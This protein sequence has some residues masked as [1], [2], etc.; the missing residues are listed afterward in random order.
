MARD[1]SGVCKLCGK[2]AQLTKEH[3]PSKGAYDRLSYRV[4]VLSGDQVFEGG[5]GEH[6]QRGFHARVLCAKCNNQTGAWYGDEFSA[7][8]KWGFQLLHAMR[9]ERPPLVA[10]Y[11]GYPARIAKQVISTMIA[12]AEDGFAERRPHLRDFVLDRHRVLE[13]DQLRLTMYL[14]PTRTGRSTGVVRALKR[15]S[16]AHVLIEFALRPFGYVLT[17]SGQPFDPRPISISWFAGCGYDE[18][19]LVVP[20]QIPVLPT[21]EAIPGDYRTRD[22]I[23][24]CVIVSIL[25]EQRHPTPE[26]E[27][28]RIMASGE[29]SEFFSQHGE[30]WTLD[31]TTGLSS[32]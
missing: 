4:R 17:L 29:G 9:Q 8:T 5:R 13:P 22:E 2:H 3:I 23:R 25:K 27:A 15:G 31:F 24:L 7:W 10:A 16:D 19:R 11:E 26:E 1:G 20:A 12:L 28:A 21:H 18:R 32:T 30:D 14:C 6:Y